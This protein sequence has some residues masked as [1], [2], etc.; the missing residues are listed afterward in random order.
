MA[1]QEM[2]EAQ[3]EQMLREYSEQKQN[4]HTFFTK[5]IQTEDTTKVGN[6]TSEELGEPRLPLRSS[7]ELELICKDLIDNP[8]W[9]D[10]FKKEAEILTST[11]LS[12]DGTLIKLSVTSKKELADVT[13]KERK[14][15]KGWF[16]KTD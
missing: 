12:K 8:G 10:Y 13:P 1:E 2:T 5:I 9:A 15:N 7:K 4:T 6:L 16:K 11:S 3:A 14:K